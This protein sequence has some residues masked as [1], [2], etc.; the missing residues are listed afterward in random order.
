[1]DLFP[2]TGEAKAKRKKWNYIKPKGTV[3]KNITI[4]MPILVGGWICGLTQS[5]TGITG[6]ETL[7]P[8]GVMDMQDDVILGEPVAFLISLIEPDYK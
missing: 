3:N 6:N 8:S 2:Q 1:M 5:Q 4:T 7:P